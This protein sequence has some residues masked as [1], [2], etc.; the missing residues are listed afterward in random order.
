MNKLPCIAV[1]IYLLLGLVSLGFAEPVSLEQSVQSSLNW[2][3]GPQET[4][5]VCQNS[6][7]NIG[8]ES[9]LNSANRLNIAATRQLAFDA[10]I[11]HLDVVRKREVLAVAEKRVGFFNNL[12]TTLEAGEGSGASDALYI[13]NVRSEGAR[14]HLVAARI[15]LR[16]AVANYSH[17]VGRQAEDTLSV[18]IPQL[19]KAASGESFG[20]AQ[21]QLAGLR[22]SVALV[23]QQLVDCTNAF[24]LSECSLVSLVDV[25]S[26]YFQLNE[27]LVDSLFVFVENIYRYFGPSELFCALQRETAP[28]DYDAF[29][30]PF[31]ELAVF[32]PDVS[33]LSGD[34]KNLQLDRTGV[35]TSVDSIRMFLDSWV[36]AWQDQDATRYLSCY[37]E[38]FEPADQRDIDAWKSARSNSLTRPEYIRLIIDDLE[39]IP[40]DGGG[41]QVRF[42][43]SY[44]SDQYHDQVQKVLTL[45]LEHEKWKIVREI[46]TPL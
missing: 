18:E 37:S 4:A 45:Q 42:S 20:E 9:V 41:Y 6:K 21:E 11:A 14:A 8:S 5:A 36:Q 33:S 46:S 1:S 22:S 7:Q 2:Q 23:Q 43:Q 32:R 44:A 25:A 34:A 31:A 27:L 26:E 38:Q 15:D 19:S 12:V 29:L 10:S 24:Q 3:F 13:G 16:V 17:I 28:V 35:D 39:L 30:S 40:L